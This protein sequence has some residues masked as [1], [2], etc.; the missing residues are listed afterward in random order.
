M[1]A[2]LATIIKINEKFDE[3]SLKFIMYQ[4]MQGLRYIHA[5]EVV[6]RDIVIL[7]I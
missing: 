5:A 2:D 4:L 6:H 7:V 1:D 3:E